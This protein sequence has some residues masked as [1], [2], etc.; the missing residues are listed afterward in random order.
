M[1]CRSDVTGCI[2]PGNR[3]NLP[4]A[5]CIARRRARALAAADADADVKVTRKPV[6]AL[7]VAVAL[8][9]VLFLAG[10]AAEPKSPTC[11]PTSPAYGD[12]LN[13]QLSNECNDKW[14][15]YYALKN[16][17]IKQ[18]LNSGD[19]DSWSI[20]GR[21]V[22]SGFFGLLG[23]GWIIRFIIAALS[24]QP[25]PQQQ[26]VPPE[27]PEQ[28]AYRE[29]MQWEAAQLREQQAAA[30]RERLRQEEQQRLAAEAQQRAQAEERERRINEEMDRIRREEL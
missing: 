22:V 4:P 27:T 23:L 5:G 7:A 6:R 17:D 30:E 3:G 9:G 1:S 20:V 18:K 2:M 21:T 11:T 12:A 29:R 15:E 14:T 19:R 13:A 16:R 28:R 26:P 25:V 24:P 10:C 8:A